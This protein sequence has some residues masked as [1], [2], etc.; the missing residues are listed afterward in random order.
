MLNGQEVSFTQSAEKWAGVK[1][2]KI[3]VGG[4]KEKYHSSENSPWKNS[5]AGKGCL[6]E[7]RKVCVAKTE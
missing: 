7:D 2:G 6:S 5:G 3:E 1:Q 4:G